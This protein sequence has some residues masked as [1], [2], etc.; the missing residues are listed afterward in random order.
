MKSVKFF[1]LVSF[2][3]GAM[4]LHA[5]ENVSFPIA[6]MAVQESET[7]VKGFFNQVSLDVGIGL[8]ET[9]RAYAKRILGV[10]NT[11]GYRFGNMFQAGLGIG[12]WSFND[13]TQ[14][15]VYLNGRLYLKKENVRPFLEGNAGTLVHLSGDEP[16]PRFFANPG[17]GLLIPWKEKMSLSTGLGIFSHFYEESG[18]DSF[19]SLKIGIVFH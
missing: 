16:S 5:G 13:G 9:N 7:V 19:V 15:P 4:L 18:R 3:A 14:L 1:L 12:V 11:F 10:S 2:L 6:N 8:A 17:A